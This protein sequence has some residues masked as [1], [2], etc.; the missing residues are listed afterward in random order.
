MREFLNHILTG[1]HRRTHLYSALPRSVCASLMAAVT[2]S[3]I[4]FISLLFHK[5]HEQV[6]IPRFLKNIGLPFCSL[7]LLEILHLNVAQEM[8][9]GSWWG[10]LSDF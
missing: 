9:V 1:L 3:F 6:T 10:G 7:N 5:A 4:I 2:R 8:H